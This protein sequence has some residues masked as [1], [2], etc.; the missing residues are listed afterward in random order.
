MTFQ[1]GAVPWH[2]LEQRR[3]APGQKAFKVEYWN[4]SAKFHPTHKVIPDVVNFLQHYT[5]RQIDPRYFSGPWFDS[6]G[7]TLLYEGENLCGFVNYDT[8]YWSVH[9][10]FVEIDIYHKKNSALCWIANVDEKCHAIRI[11][12]TDLICEFG[13]GVQAWNIVTLEEN[14]FLKLF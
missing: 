10:G 4:L 14:S 9:T 5:S 2:L 6:D 3:V 12:G 1:A 7:E 8:T 11:E 13:A